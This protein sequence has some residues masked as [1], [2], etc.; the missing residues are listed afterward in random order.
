MKTSRLTDEQIAMARRQ[1][2]AGTPIGEICRRS[3]SKATA[4]GLSGRMCWASSRSDAS[5]G[6]RPDTPGGPPRRLAGAV[7]PHLRHAGPN[8]HWGKRRKFLK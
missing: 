5:R 6:S 1:P 7:S 8:L 3:C 2:E 4:S